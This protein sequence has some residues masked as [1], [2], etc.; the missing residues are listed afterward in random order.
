M[1]IE[2]LIEREMKPA[3]F[4]WW[5]H[6]YVDVVPALVSEP[7]GDGQVLMGFSSTDCRPYHWLLRVDSSVLSMDEDE[8]NEYVETFV[9]EAIGDAFGECTCDDECN[10]RFPVLVLYSGGYSWWIE[11]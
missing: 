5:G 1:T 3:S 2:E 10:C 8:L 11:K 6:D 7:L 4:R 9:I